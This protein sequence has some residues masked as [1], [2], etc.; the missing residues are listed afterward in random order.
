MTFS[1]DDGS[2]YLIY[3]FVA[4]PI[5]ITFPFVVRIRSRLRL[6]RQYHTQTILALYEAPAKLTP[7]EI[8]YIYD[9][10]LN[11]RELIATIFDLEYRNIIQIDETGRLTLGNTSSQPLKPHETYAI[12]LIQNNT[13]ASVTQPIDHAILRPFEKAVR[14]TLIMQQY[15]NKSYLSSLIIQSFKI[16][17]Y[18]FLVSTA[19]FVLYASLIQ[20]PPTTSL[21]A[22]LFM[23]I[24]ILI[25]FTILF[26]PL[27]IGLSVL[28]IIMY[29]KLDGV[30]WIGTKP[31]RKIWPEI[32]GYRMYI[33]QAQLNRLNFASEE[34]RSK[35]IERD[36]AYAVALGMK[37]D[38]IARF[39]Q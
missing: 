28:L 18:V 25:V 19:I 35:A 22:I 17:G 32:E 39:R 24:M 20:Y 34:L 31:L 3:L 13:L 9:T 30:H 21:G 37:L 16:C 8:G 1:T 36:F 12:S 29:V 26:F 33:K 4:L 2:I 23:S 14:Q 6:R 7:A 5:L 11:G 38:W 27:Y 10:K 15:M